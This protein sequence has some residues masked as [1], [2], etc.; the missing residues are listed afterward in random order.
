MGVQGVI[1]ANQGLRAAVAA[2]RQTYKAILSNGST[3][4]VE[5][6]IASVSDIFALQGLDELNSI[7]MIVNSVLGE[8]SE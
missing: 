5:A 1:F 2:V 7:D 3:A 8:K 6:H 4:P